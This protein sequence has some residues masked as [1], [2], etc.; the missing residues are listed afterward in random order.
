MSPA[1]TSAWLKLVIAVPGAETRSNRPPE[2]PEMLTVRLGARLSTSLAERSAPLSTTLAPSLTVRLL[3][4][5]SGGSFTPM[6]LMR[7]GE[8]PS[9][10]VPSET[11]TS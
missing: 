10:R 11:V 2:R 9:D 8:G 1:L 7:A 5:S 3:L 6:K 4:P